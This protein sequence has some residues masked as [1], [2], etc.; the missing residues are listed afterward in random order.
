[1]HVPAL[2]DLSVGRKLTFLV[3]FFLIALTLVGI[4]GRLGIA[5]MSDSTR[6]ITE[7]QLPA[8]NILSTIRGQ[9]AV[10]VQ[11][12]LDVSTRETDTGAQDAF[13]SIL[14]NKIKAIE[15]LKVAMADF[16]KL[17]LSDDEAAA[18]KEFKIAVA[19]WLVTDVQANEM[20]KALGDNTEE[21]IQASLFGKFKNHV[22]EWLQQV[23][24][25]NKAL[26]KLLDANMK[27]GLQARSDSNATEQLATRFM[28]ATYGTAIVV[29]LLLAFFIVR[30]ITG[31]LGRMRQAI[32]QVAS[33]N[34][35][36]LH[37]DVSGRDE[38]GQT[39]SAF[40]GLLE[41]IRLSLLD[42]RSNAERVADVAN[43]AMSASD[44]VS[45]A[46]TH[47]SESAAAIAAAIEQLTV[48][49]AMIGNNMRDVL[50]RSVEAGSTANSG[51]EMIVRAKNEMDCIVGTVRDAEVIID[52]LGQQTNRISVV[53]KVIHDVADQTNLLALNAAIEAARAGEQ[54]R[55]FAVVADEVR[56][57]AERTQNS[58]VEINGTINAM[59]IAASNAVRTM[60]QVMQQVVKGKE[61]SDQ[62]AECMA[63]IRS[64]IARVEVAIHEISSALN[65]QGSAT[66]D[67]SQQVEAVAHMSEENSHASGA[68]AKASHDLNEL[69]SSL[70]AAVNQFRL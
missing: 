67:I 17:P 56:K 4:G 33:E 66:Q 6:L 45:E 46:S 44:R 55:G 48:S 8:A 49:I 43:G 19:N 37:A 69:S 27:A 31:P 53:L 32:V 70:L 36:T 14:A 9:T 50:T 52:E 1:M 57:L 18:W 12:S 24:T 62:A 42:V 38:A 60:E 39:A 23:E 51:T 64:G 40:N 16:E 58:T 22:F 2:R 47:Q 34:D 30:S 59:E 61:S 63:A 7:N 5:R 68:T 15:T 65:E 41:K 3:A 54:G 21:D 28:S 11:Y 13:K 35:F 26:S 25:V 10:M 20:I 29:S